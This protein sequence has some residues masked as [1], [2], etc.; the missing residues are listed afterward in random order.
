MISDIDELRVT[1]INSG[2]DPICEATR[3]IGVLWAELDAKRREN[4][5]LKDK[6]K[7][8]EKK[9]NEDDK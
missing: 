2:R 1:R 7:Y 4:L 6:V 9:L 3:L 5:Y 8:L